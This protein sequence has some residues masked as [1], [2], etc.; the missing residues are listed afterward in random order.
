ME[1]AGRLTGSR[2][3][4]D[5]TL[6][7]DSE[8]EAESTGPAGAGSHIQAVTSSA[9]PLVDGPSSSSAVSSQGIKVEKPEACDPTRGAVCLLRL[10]A[11]L[12]NFSQHI[13]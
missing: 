9:A 8:D 2:M 10:N 5:L 7:S 1:V 4:M 3:F 13:F 11:Q 12:M 6:D